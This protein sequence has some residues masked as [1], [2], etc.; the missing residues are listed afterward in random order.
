M[1]KRCATVFAFLLMFSMGAKAA[2]SDDLSD[3]AFIENISG[4]TDYMNR[5]A[6]TAKR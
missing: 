6:A 3:V 1:S 4:L 5:M 2:F